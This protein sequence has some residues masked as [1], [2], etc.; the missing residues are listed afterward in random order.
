ME[1][2]P[3]EILAL[4]KAIPSKEAKEARKAIANDSKVEVDIL[5]RVQGVVKR[6]SKPKP[7]KG[8]VEGGHR[9]VPQAV[10]GYWDCL[11]PPPR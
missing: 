3:E 7:S 10:W 11:C 9:A 8:T 4:V 5:V 2:T 1:L 6:A